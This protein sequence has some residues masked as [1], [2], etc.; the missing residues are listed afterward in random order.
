MRALDSS[1]SVSCVSSVS[2][3]ARRSRAGLSLIELLVCIA[4][5]ALLISVL[6]PSLA[7]ARQ[8]AR[9][10]VCT[11]NMR[12]LGV[13]THTYAGQ[14]DDRLYSYSWGR[15][16][17]DG[18]DSGSTLRILQDGYNPNDPAMAGL[19]VTDGDTATS[20]AAKQATYFIRTQSGR[21][22]DVPVPSNWVPHLLYS[23]L[24]LQNVMEQIIP[25]K[26]VTCPQD[27]NRLLWQDWRAFER[28][29]FLPNQPN[30]TDENNKR[31]P[32]SSS[33]QT[34]PAHYSPDVRKGASNTVGQGAAHNQFLVD[35]IRPDSLGKRRIT[36]VRFPSQKVQ[37]YDAEDRHSAPQSVFY[38]TSFARST[39]LMY[40]QSV[41]TRR[42][43][44]ALPGFNPRT[45]TSPTS[46]FWTTIT[47]T[48]SPWETPFGASGQPGYYRWTTG[49]LK[50]ID[51]VSGQSAAWSTPT[52]AQQYEVRGPF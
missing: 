18:T 26:V 43:S 9:T 52:Q 29:Q 27:R 16:T 36:D 33:Y 48:P 46:Y 31:W 35:G 4:I 38:T 15:V 21:G 2:S 42:T 6:L 8:S 28:N 40:D 19:Q 5:I 11:M 1:A 37:M 25:A 22:T 24:V 3:S 39:L 32:Y 20:A 13:A 45:Y 14:F 10:L 30:G 51:F 47:Y 49:G 41:S 12:Q 50:G 17:S 34:V 44:D 7:K 23:H